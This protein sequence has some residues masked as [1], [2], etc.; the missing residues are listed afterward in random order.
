MLSQRRRLVVGKEST[1]RWC[2]LYT[3]HVRGAIQR[4]S[5]VRLVSRSHYQ[6]RRGQSTQGA[7]QSSRYFPHPRFREITRF[8]LHSLSRVLHTLPAWVSISHLHKL[9]GLTV[10]LKRTYKFGFCKELLHISTLS[11]PRSH[12]YSLPQ[13]R[14]VTY[15]NLLINWCLFALL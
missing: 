3:E 12:K 9:L 2:G 14:Y 1:N 15:K 13:C 4:P 6:E 8:H 7:Q 5:V 10:F 11:S